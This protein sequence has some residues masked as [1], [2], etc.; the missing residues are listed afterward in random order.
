MQKSLE[1]ENVTVYMNFTSVCTLKVYK[2]C[3]L[4]Q[5]RFTNLDKFKFIVLAV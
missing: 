4:S 5:Q 1:D 3:Q 2:K